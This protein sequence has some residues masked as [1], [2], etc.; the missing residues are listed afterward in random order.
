MR[1]SCG[2]STRNEA[3]QHSFRIVFFSPLFVRARNK[4][5]AFGS[6]DMHNLPTQTRADDRQRYLPTACMQQPGI[7]L[8]PQFGLYVDYTYPLLPPPHAAHRRITPLPLCPSL[9]HLLFRWADVLFIYTPLPLRRR[10]RSI[11][12]LRPIVAVLPPA[13]P[14]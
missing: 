2:Q 14:A 10:A 1:A 8:K 4:Y 3:Q 9:M 5:A 7:A 11:N 12:Y 13:E 6:N